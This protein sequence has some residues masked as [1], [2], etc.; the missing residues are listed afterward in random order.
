MAAEVHGKTRLFVG[1]FDLSKAFFKTANVIAQSSQKPFGMLRGDNNSGFD[2]RFRDTRHQADEVDHELTAGVGYHGQI[3]IL[4]LG[5]LF[6][7]LDVDLVFLCYVL[8]HFICSIIRPDG[9][10]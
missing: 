2:L 9:L 8:R 4:A 1:L 5:D 6:A 10:W 7:Q 3:R